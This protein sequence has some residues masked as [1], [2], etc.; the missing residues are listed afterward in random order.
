M[1]HSQFILTWGPGAILEGP[2]GPRIVPMPEIGLFYKKHIKPEDFEI[3]DSRMSKGLLNNRRIFRLPSNAELNIDE[4]Y[5]V[6]MT[7]MFPEWSICVTHGIL[8]LR[9]YGC[10]KCKRE[11]KRGKW[12]AIRFVQACPEGHLDDVDWDYIV[13]YRSH[14]RCPSPTSP[15]KRYYIWKGGGGSLRNIRI[16]CPRCGAAVNFGD[17]YRRDWPCSGRFPEREPLNFPPQRKG[18]SSSA[19]II[20]RQASNLRIPEIVSLFTIPPRYTRLHNLLEMPAIKSALVTH[21][22]SS[23]EELQSILLS[24][25]NNGLIKAGTMVEILSHPWEEIRDAIKDVLSSSYELGYANLILEEYHALINASIYGVPPVRGPPP[26]S[27]VWFEVVK[28]KVRQV[29]GPSGRIFRVVPITRLRTVIVQK[30]YRRMDP[31]GKLIEVWFRDRN[32]EEWYPGVEFL[33]EGIFIMLD[34]NEGYHPQ[35]ASDSWEEWHRCHATHKD[36]STVYQHMIFR[37]PSKKE[38][39]HPVFVWWHTL[40]HLLLRVLAIDSGYSSASIRER[41]YFE[42]SEKGVRGG[43]VLYTVQPGE[44]TMGGLLSLANHFEKIL[45]RAIEIAETCPNDPLCIEQAFKCGAVTGSACY[46]CLLVSETSCEHRNMWLDRH[47]LLED[48]P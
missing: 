7:K 4:N 39:L 25:K 11:R 19:K 3:S 37:D 16:E 5:P 40:S 36:T 8:F 41:V 18:C 46:G 27:E 10:P 12:D 24:L 9:R 48:C 15:S 21:K 43:V 6:Y 17:M 32:G 33:G 22:I 35:V 47:V 13:H 38:E 34:K 28:D 29:S 20:L 2:E 23:M 42:M 44:G 31:N 14:G 30:G 26:T 1:R 45:R